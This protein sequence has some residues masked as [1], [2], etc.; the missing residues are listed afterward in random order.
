ME[1][2]DY[3]RTI[4][5]KRRKRGQL[6]GPRTGKD[7]YLVIETID[8]EYDIVYVRDVTKK[9]PAAMPLPSLHPD[10]SVYFE[11]TK[12]RGTKIER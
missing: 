4:R 3:Q 1:V 8:D 11:W 12:P 5:L 7:G 10:G 2:P 6:F 9:Y